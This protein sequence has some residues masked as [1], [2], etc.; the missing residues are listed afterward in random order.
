MNPRQLAKL[1]VPKYCHPAA[2]QAVQS[3]AKFNRTVEKPLRIDVKNVV[4]QCVNDPDTFTGHTHLADLAKELIADREFVRPEPVDYQTWGNDG[5]DP[6]A[7]AQME[8]ACSM[9][10]AFGGALMA[11]AHLGYGLPIGGVLALKDA[12]CPYAVGVDIACRMKMTV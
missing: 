12:I 1:G 10:N 4:A 2:L 8:Q 7:H 11:D 3:I 5:I 6:N 9:P